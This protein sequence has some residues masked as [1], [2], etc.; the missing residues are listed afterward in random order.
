ME[1]FSLTEKKLWLEKERSLLRFSILFPVPFRLI[2]S[3]PSESGKVS[4]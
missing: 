1:N 3:G 2:L 4:E